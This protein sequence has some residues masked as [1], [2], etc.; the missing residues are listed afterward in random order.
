ML[1]QLPSSISQLSDEQLYEKYGQPDLEPVTRFD[2]KELGPG[3]QSHGIFPIRLI[4]KEEVKLSDAKLM[5]IDFGESFAPSQETKYI[6]NTPLNERP[7]EGRFERKKKP[8]SFPSDIWSLACAIWSLLCQRPLFQTFFPID[9]EITCEQ[10]D[11]LGILPPEW[12]QRWKARGKYF[13]NDGTPLEQRK[14][15]AWSLDKC[16]ERS[17]QEP[18]RE[19]GMVPFEQDEK[20]ALLVMLRAM[21]AYKP[22]DRITVVGVLQ[23]EWMTKWAMPEYEKVRQMDDSWALTHCLHLTLPSTMLYWIDRSA[24]PFWLEVYGS[25]VW[26]ATP[27]FSHSWRVSRISGA[28]SVLE[29]FNLCP[30]SSSA[31]TFHLLSLGRISLRSLKRR[32][33]DFLDQLSTIPPS[34]GVTVGRIFIYEFSA[35]RQSWHIGYRRRL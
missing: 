17:T 8:F 5:L 1:L 18:R 19:R 15:D 16:F 14:E 24:S 34:V 9:D 7:P 21:L 30:V 13:N 31:W 3:I 28:L 27:E 22:E 4:T 25:V 12:W 10:V 2:G 26:T 6:L 20:E 11:A 32:V 29:A 23:S 33:Q 35:N